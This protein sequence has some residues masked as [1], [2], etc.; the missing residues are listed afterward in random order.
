M[1]AVTK[2]LTFFAPKYPPSVLMM[3]RHI[4]ITDLAPTFYRAILLES[5]EG[6]GFPLFL[7]VGAG[8]KLLPL[9]N[10]KIVAE[11]GS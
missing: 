8:F 4:Y 5:M 1:G 11:A 3:N 7:R 2:K 6:D 10:Q 9:K